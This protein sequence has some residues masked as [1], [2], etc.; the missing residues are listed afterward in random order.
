[1]NPILN[2]VLAQLDEDSTAVDLSFK[3]GVPVVIAI[4]GT[5]KANKF[6]AAL[7]TSYPAARISY[8]LGNSQSRLV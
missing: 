2:T 8:E 1:V 6:Y 3:P 7:D 5:L 4:L